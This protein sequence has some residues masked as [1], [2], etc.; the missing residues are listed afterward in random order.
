M[1]AYEIK[2]GQELT[3][4]LVQ[5]SAGGKTYAVRP[6]H[7]CNICCGVGKMIVIDKPERHCEC[8][9]RRLRQL[10]VGKLPARIQ[11]TPT[12]P[13]TPQLER[14]H[15]L[16]AKIATRERELAAARAQLD[17][18]ETQYQG[19]TNRF[20]AHIDAAESARWHWADLAT[21]LEGEAAKAV[22]EAQ[23]A[24][25][26]AKRFARSAAE[27]VG[28]FRQREQ[29]AADQLVALEAELTP[30]QKIHEAARRR[31]LGEIRRKGGQLERLRAR[32]ARRE[33]TDTNGKGQ[34]NGEPAEKTEV[35][36]ARGAL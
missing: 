34:G 23:D 7:K 15:E 3:K 13:G 29:A 28:D 25:D 17:A 21:G 33:G 36:Q 10:I 4:G 14:N 20:Q 26:S 30:T 27:S 6:N 31:P 1:N 32:L 9:V 35:A 24:L 12:N 19:E 16:K 11:S 22:A 18:L 5:I 2:E 8:V